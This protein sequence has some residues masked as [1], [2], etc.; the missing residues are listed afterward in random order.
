MKAAFAVNE[1]ALV[2]AEITRFVRLDFVLFCLG[3]IIDIALTGTHRSIPVNYRSIIG[4]F[5]GAPIAC[6]HPKASRF[7]VN[8]SAYPSGRIPFLCRG[9][10][11]FRLV[12]VG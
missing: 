3:A 9:R 11:A 10:R 5:S 2:V 1:D 7:S 6:L 4:R 12:I 8:S